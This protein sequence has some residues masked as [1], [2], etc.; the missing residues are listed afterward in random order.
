MGGQRERGALVSKFMAQTWGLGL[1]NRRCQSVDHLGREVI[2]LT[3]H[4]TDSCPPP[5]LPFPWSCLR[6]PPEVG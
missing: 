2:T 3:F 1:V 5:S 6:V 4:P